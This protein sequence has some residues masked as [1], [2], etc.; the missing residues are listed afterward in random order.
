MEFFVQRPRQRREQRPPPPPLRPAVSLVADDWDDFGL[1]TS[2]AVFYTDAQGNEREIGATKILQRGER[3]TTLPMRFQSLGEGFCS[4]GQSVE[5][6][7]ALLLLGQETAHEILRA[8]RD[9]VFEP[10][11]GEGLRDSE[12]FSKSLLRFSEAEKAYKEGGRLFGRVPISSEGFAFSFSC[13]L[14]GF[15]R[16]HELMLDFRPVAGL[17]HRIITFVGKNGTGKSGV[18]ARLATTLSGWDQAPPGSFTPGRPQFSRVLSL[19][20]S[21]F[22][23]FEVPRVNSTS[24]RYCGLRNADN[25]VDLNALHE[26]TVRTVEALRSSGREQ[27]W[28]ELMRLEDLLGTQLLDLGTPRGL[29]EFS[30]LLRTLSSGQRLMVSLFSDLLEHIS[31]ESLLLLDE[32]E[33][34]LHPTLISTLMR[35]LHRLLEQY[36]SYAVVATHSPIVVQEIPARSVRVFERLGN[37]PSQSP[38]AVESFGE[39]LTELVD[40]VFHM[41]EDDKNYK[42]LL[43]ELAKKNGHDYEKMLALFDNRLSLNARMYLLS[44]ARKG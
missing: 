29:Q 23:P 31:P 20:Y 8:L 26:R 41:N 35:M 6:Y 11:H 13:K 44:L 18:L 1:R 5:Y 22:Q 15:S 7:Q 12:G 10:A 17:P 43:Q 40:H 27:V 37:V 4:L 38:L 30:T 19:S 36:D 24:Y 3:K 14:E 42:T 21:L 32:P 39:N 16:P 34:Y 25:K 2:F 9:V 28:L 33:T